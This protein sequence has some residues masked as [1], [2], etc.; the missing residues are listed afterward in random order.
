MNAETLGALWANVLARKEVLSHLSED[1]IER[2]Y[3]LWIRPGDVA[4]D[5]GANIGRHTLPLAEAVGEA[6]HVYAFE[7]LPEMIMKLT[8]R[9]TASGLAQ[10]IT[11]KQMAIGDRIG[12]ADFHFIHKAPAM[13]G[14]KLRHGLPEGT[15]TDVR[16]VSLATLDELLGDRLLRFVKIDVEGA[17]FSVM[18]G[19]SLLMTRARPAFAFEDGRYGSAQLYGYKMSEFYDFF[20]SKNYLI[21]DLFGFPISDEMSKYAGPWNFFAI[22]NEALPEFGQ[23]VVYAGLYETWLRMK[24]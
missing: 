15:K 2:A 13:S 11:L 22:P 6:G 18:R 10:R 24:G 19:A 8:S 21:V 7:P 20:K 17:E 3:R 16:Q 1:V 4:V 9:V 12:T 14:L 5:V 23:I